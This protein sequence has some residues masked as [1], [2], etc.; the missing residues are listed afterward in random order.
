MITTNIP[1][2]FPGERY[3]LLFL[4]GVLILVFSYICAALCSKSVESFLMGGR[5]CCGC[6]RSQEIQL[7]KVMSRQTLSWN[8]SL[9]TGTHVSSG[10]VSLGAEDLPG[11]EVLTPAWG[12]S[13]GSEDL[14]PS[15]EVT[16]VQ[17]HHVSDRMPENEAMV[18]FPEALLNKSVSC[19]ILEAPV[20]GE[21]LSVSRQ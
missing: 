5:S 3:Y 2:Y 11:S 21:D 4:A 6:E 16:S 15:W 19:P 8:D 9:P 13:D 17:V 18:L 14:P 1:F 7:V 20:E 10:N 12:D